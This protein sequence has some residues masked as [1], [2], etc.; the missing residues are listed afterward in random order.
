MVFGTEDHLEKD[1]YIVACKLDDNSDIVDYHRFH[2]PSGTSRDG[3]PLVRKEA[4]IGIRI[5][6]E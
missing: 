6:V 4:S 2:I 3:A 5:L 1:Q